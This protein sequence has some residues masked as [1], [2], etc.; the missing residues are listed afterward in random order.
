MKKNPV[1]QM[2]PKLSIGAEIGVW[3]GESSKELMRIAHPKRLHLI[4]PWRFQ[5]EFSHRM[6]GGAVAKSQT[7]MEHIYA[8]IMSDFGKNPNII[9]HRDFSHN[10]APLFNDEY[11]DWIY[12]DG[13][14]YYEYVLKDIQLYFP[15][16]KKGGLLIGD[17]YFWSSPELNGD[18]P[19]KRAVQYFLKEYP[20]KLTIIN[21]QFIINK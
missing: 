2:L 10:A 18:Q 4:D 11:F 9:V 20:L 16:L 19:V 14:H 1:F 13:N 3:K 12:I 7:D 15:K 6:Y 17:D 21:N 5:D 8:G